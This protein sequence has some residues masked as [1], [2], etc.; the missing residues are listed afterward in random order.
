MTIR[1]H[2][3]AVADLTRIHSYIA[4]ENPIAASSVSERILRSVDR[5]DRFPLSG[6]AGK[7]SGTREVV[8]LG[9]PYIVVYRQD[10]S[11][12]SVVAVLHGAQQS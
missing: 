2:P 10:E 1:W 4:Q 8:V 9:L 6:R 11:G 12:V 7:A 5:L 3:K